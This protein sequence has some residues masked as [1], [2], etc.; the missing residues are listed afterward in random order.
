MVS[1]PVAMARNAFAA[2]PDWHRM[3]DTRYSNV[4]SGT[5]LYGKHGSIELE[6]EESAGKL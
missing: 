5:G 1:H 3:R 2:G 4:A 6:T